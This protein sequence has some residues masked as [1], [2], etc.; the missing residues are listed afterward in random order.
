MFFCVSSEAFLKRRSYVNGFF[1]RAA[2]WGGAL[3]S[4]SMATDKKEGRSAN[5]KH[6]R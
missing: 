2:G 6:V 5:L 1:T 3:S 4:H